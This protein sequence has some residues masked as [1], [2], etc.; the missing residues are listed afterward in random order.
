MDLAEAASFNLGK[1]RSRWPERREYT[2]LFDEPFDPIERFPR[3]IRMHIFEKRRGD[4]TYVIQ[5][6]NGIN[7]GAAL[8]D[9]RMNLMITASTMYSIGYAAILGW[10]P[11]LRALFNLKRKSK[12]Q[13]DE[14]QDG[15]GQLLLKKESQP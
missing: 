9:N 14:A 5:Q 4:K 12:L 11:V 15:A 10:S 6:C 8:T 3:T 1:I 2:H 13:V 7:I